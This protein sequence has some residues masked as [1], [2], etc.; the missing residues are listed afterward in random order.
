[1]SNYEEPQVPRVKKRKLFNLSAIYSDNLEDHVPTKA[2]KSIATN[3]VVEPMELS[4]ASIDEEAEHTDNEEQEENEEREE[5]VR[6][7]GAKKR[8]KK[9]T[10]F[11][12]I[13]SRSKY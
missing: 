7:K 5:V 3:N 6:P 12:A 13:E 11:A 2:E 9:K 1:M 8:S 4:D 10:S